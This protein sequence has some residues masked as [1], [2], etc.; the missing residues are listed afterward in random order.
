MLDISQS[1]QSLDPSDIADNLFH[2]EYNTKHLLSLI[3]KGID[4]EDPAYMSSFG[5]FEGEVCENFI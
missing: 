1:I 3:K 5:S 4:V 2:Y